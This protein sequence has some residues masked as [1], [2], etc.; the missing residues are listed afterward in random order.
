MTTTP[1]CEGVI[2]DMDGLMLD[3]EPI[4]RSAWR[5]ACSTLGYSLSD[6]LFDRLIGRSEKDSEAI[7]V[8]EFGPDF[9]VRRF[10]DIYN[11]RTDATI[12]TTPVPLMD[13]ITEI[14][15]FLKVRGLPRVVATSTKRERAM[16]LLESSGLKGWFDAV[17]T[18]DQVTKGKPEPEIFLSAAAAIGVPAARC[19]VLEDSEPGILAARAAGA[20]PMMVP[21]LKKPGEEIIRQAFGVYQS[22]HEVQ[23]VLAAILCE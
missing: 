14:L 16:K 4:Y 8:K 18:G 9:P 3:T 10:R 2:F 13:G 7:V 5:Y 12:A 6:E 22:L 21:G 1:I 23:G 15:D 17:V 11:E 20:I 19:V